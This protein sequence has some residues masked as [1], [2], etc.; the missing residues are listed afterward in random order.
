MEKLPLCGK[1]L[2][3]VVKPETPA[4]PGKALSNKQLLQNGY[5]KYRSTKMCPNIIPMLYFYSRYSCIINPMWIVKFLM[6]TLV[7]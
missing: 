3:C 2:H 1:K 5:K 6:T 7:Y 4:H